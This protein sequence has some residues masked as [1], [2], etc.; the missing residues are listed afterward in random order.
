MV[1]L[2]RKAL[3][4]WHRWRLRIVVSL[5]G[6]GICHGIVADRS[7]AADWPTYRGDA[8]RSNYTAET[9]PAELS[10]AWQYEPGHA[11]QPAWSGRFRQLGRLPDPRPGR[12]H[13]RPAVVVLHRG[14]RALRPGGVR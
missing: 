9:L 8:R 5:L 4:M 12:R 3:Q 10:L 6:I 2:R 1:E 7:P 14:A 13:G 11:P